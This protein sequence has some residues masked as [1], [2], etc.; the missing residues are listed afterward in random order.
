M[1]K[2]NVFFNL[3]SRKIYSVDYVRLL[4]TR[5]KSDH[6]TYIIVILTVRIFCTAFLQAF[7]AISVCPPKL[8]PK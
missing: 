3:T 1:G 7:P 6:I 5:Y 8:F 2:R 4:Y